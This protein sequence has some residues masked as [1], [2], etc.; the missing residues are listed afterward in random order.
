VLVQHTI[1]N[2]RDR[3]RPHNNHRG[4]SRHCRVSDRL[5]S[6]SDTGGARNSS[7]AYRDRYRIGP[8]DAQNYFSDARKSEIGE[9]GAQLALIRIAGESR[10]GFFRK[11]QAPFLEIRRNFFA[12]FYLASSARLGAIDRERKRTAAR[13][14]CACQQFVTCG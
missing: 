9:V 10:F 14:R 4:H 5:E 13:A 11:S 7:D 2:R 1:G 8:G 3:V 12:R 6:P